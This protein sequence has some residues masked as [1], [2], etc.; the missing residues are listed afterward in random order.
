[1]AS[2]KKSDV[3]TTDDAGQAEAATEERDAGERLRIDRVA[4][5]EDL[6]ELVRPPAELPVPEADRVEEPDDGLG[7]L[8]LELPVP[9]AVVA[10]LEL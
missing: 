9:G 2:T 5:R 8:L 10:G 6:G 4:L 7:D 1:M 3:S